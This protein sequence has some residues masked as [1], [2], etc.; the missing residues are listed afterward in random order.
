MTRVLL[1]L[2]LLAACES[3]PAPPVATPTTSAGELRAF[4]PGPFTHA[5]PKPESGD[6]LAMQR[7]EGQTFEQFTEAERQVPNVERRVIYLQPIGEFEPGR[8]VELERLREFTVAFFE[9]PV[10]INPPI[11]SDQFESRDHPDFGRQLRSG[12]VLERLIPMLPANAF[13]MLGV[14]M[15]DLYPEDDWNFVF[16]MAA[17]VERTGVFSFARYSPGKDTEPSE[18]QTKLM[19]LRAFKILA[20]EIGHM[21]GIKHCTAYLCGMNG[22]N[23]LTETDRAPL[24]Y[25]PVCLRK[26]QSS[27]GFDVVERDERLAAVLSS[28]GLDA[29]AQWHLNRRDWILAK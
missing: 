18:S 27:V 19:T 10:V 24:G 7:E 5:L 28:A 14:T 22:S 3:T 21:F 17:L 23:S 11:S 9:L 15:E 12:D 26:L 2:L 16:G 8:A 29:N 13:C 25:C 6:W 4:Q 20:H 1:L